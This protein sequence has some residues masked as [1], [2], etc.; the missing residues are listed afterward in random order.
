MVSSPDLV[1]R[2]LEARDSPLTAP[3]RSAL[4]RR[5]SWSQRTPA[6]SRLRRRA[7]F[8]EVCCCLK[9]I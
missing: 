8:Q 4:I 6:V 5:C 9:A 2:H 1:V 7:F 3:S